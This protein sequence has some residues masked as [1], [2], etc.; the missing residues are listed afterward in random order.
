MTHK[1]DWVEAQQFYCST[2]NGNKICWPVRVLRADSS[3]WKYVVG[4]AGR[5]KG[6]EFTVIGSEI[7][8][9]VPK[10]YKLAPGARAFVPKQAPEVRKVDLIRKRISKIPFTQNSINL[11]VSKAQAK[12]L[13]TEIDNQA[14]SL[15]PRTLTDRAWPMYDDDREEAHEY[16][17]DGKTSYALGSL[18][19][20]IDM[21]RG[22]ASREK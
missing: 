2:L 13:F 7:S 16:I 18:V 1:H 4:Q 3:G 12:K 6:R 10:G 20:M 14:K 22:A 19:K 21:I 17:V 8:A 9:Y 15:Y 11:H 5:F